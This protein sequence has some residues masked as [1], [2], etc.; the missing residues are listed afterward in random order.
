MATA[1]RLSDQQTPRRRG[2]AAGVVVVLVAL[3]AAGAGAWYAKG[4]GYRAWVS[5]QYFGGALPGAK[6][7]AVS[8][9]RPGHYDGNVPLDGFVAADVELPN[10]GYVVDGR[11]V[12]PATVRLFRTADKSEVAAAVNTSGGGDAIVLKPSEPLQP[13]TQYTFEVNAGVR[14]TAGAAF[15]YF[16]S[17]FTTAA[18]AELV[19]LPVAFEKVALPAADGEMFTSLA[20]GPD[21]KL[22]GSTMDGRVMRFAVAPDGSLSDAQTVPTIAAH[23]HGPRLVTGICFDPAA[24][25]QNPVL[26]VSHG[27]LV[28]KEATDWTGKISRLSGPNLSDYQDYVVGLPRAVRDHLNNQPVFGPDGALYF[29]QASN[30]AMGAPDERWGM[31]PEHALTAAVLRLDVAKVTRPPLDAKTDEGG[32]YDPAAPGAPLTVFATGVRN[33]Y[34]LLWHGNGRLYGPLNAS[35]AGGNTPAP[36]DEKSCGRRVPSLARLARTLDDTLVRIDP[37]AY[38]GH[39]NPLRGEYVLNGGNP[40]AGAD[41]AEIPEYP[42]GTMPEKH[43]RP[44]VYTFGKNLSPTGVIEYRN[45]SAF[46]GALRGKVLVCRYSGGD[47]VL[48]LSLGAN[49]E[50]TEAVSG[51]EGFTRLMDPLDLVEDAATGHL[52]VAEFQ[53]K[54]ITLLRPKAGGVSRV[55]RQLVSQ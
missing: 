53:P 13:N 54:R 4:R 46:G 30:T 11:T 29:C 27:Q 3:A 52:Y 40:T 23:N 42:V 50:V 6:R 51:V 20:F 19:E 55:S 15:E 25:A 26:W 21:R 33:S 8:A 14:D 28:L 32:T 49:G 39:P 44:P 17:S 48:V 16:S 36:P 9:T 1:A 45:E 12:T 22:Y 43:W 47:D 7:P 24:T 5:H 38:F 10:G 31:R 35:A 2:R 18:A 37:G 34:D 41:P